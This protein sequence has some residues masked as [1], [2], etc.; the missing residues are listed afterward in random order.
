[1]IRRGNQSITVI[2]FLIVDPT[3]LDFIPTI[4]KPSLVNNTIP[5]L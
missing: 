2:T 4:S 3:P 5:G 1:M